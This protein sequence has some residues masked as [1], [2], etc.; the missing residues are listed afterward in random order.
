[1]LKD[2]IDK[3]TETLQRVR[4]VETRLTKLGKLLG[5]DLTKDKERMARHGDDWASI[6]IGGLDVSISDILTFCRN[7]GMLHVVTI[8]HKGQTVGHINTEVIS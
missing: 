5:H 2:Y 3:E 6:E 1:M 8:T 7:T 4:R